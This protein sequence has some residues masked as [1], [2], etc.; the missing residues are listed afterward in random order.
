MVCYNCEN[1]KLW[2]VYEGVS[3]PCEYVYRL[4]CVAVC[5]CVVC[6]KNWRIIVTYTHIHTYIR[7]VC[8]MH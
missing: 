3:P 2:K 7:V 4:V 1:R 5:V 6:C 8:E